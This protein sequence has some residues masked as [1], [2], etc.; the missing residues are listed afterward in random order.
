MEL[1]KQRYRWRI[2]LAL[3]GMVI[4]TITSFYSYFLAQ[5]LADKEVKSVKL[6]ALALEEAYKNDDLDA[7]MILIDQIIQNNTVPI[8]TEDE[9]GDLEGYNYKESLEFDQ[10]F[11]AKQKRKS[12][13][14][15]FEPIE[16]TGYSRYIYLNNSRLYNLIRLYPL[17]QFILVAIFI[18]L[19]YLVFSASR[20]EE[21]NRVWAGMAKETAHQ[22][23]TPISAII[24]WLEHLKLDENTNESQLEIINELANDVDRLNLVADRFSK[25]GSAPNLERCRFWRSACSFMPNHNWHITSQLGHFIHVP[26]WIA[27]Y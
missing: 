14:R 26:R 11:L 15:G 18:L 2:L 9:N 5:E 17:V 10:E 8:V 6:F 21:Q 7:N 12:I 24:A 13:N 23:G 1:Y 16:G 25:I 27:Q 3:F 22:L 19:G 20:R 4:I